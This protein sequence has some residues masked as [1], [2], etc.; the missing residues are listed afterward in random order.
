MNK[1]EAKERIGKLKEV[2]NHH[3]YL[4]HVLDK[5]EMSESALD[6][7][8]HELYTLEQQFP[9]LITSDSPTQRIGGQP[10]PAFKKVRHERP[11]LS[12]E[13]VFSEDEFQAWMDRIEKLIPGAAATVYCMPK[14]DGLAMSL[15]YENG[16]FTAA[17]T[18]GD[19]KFGEDVTQNIRTVESVPLR[20]RIPSK[21]E[22]E[23]FHEQF[24]DSSISTQLIENGRLE[25][26]GEIY[27]TK[28]DFEIM[29]ER[30]AKDG[31]ALFANPRNISAGSIRQLDPS[32][33][34]SRPLRFMA[35]NL[36]TDI[37][38]KTQAASMALL[39]LFGFTTP[40]GEETTNIDG[41]KRIFDQVHKKREKLPFWIDGLVVRV[42]R[43][44][45][46]ERLGVVGKTPR[47]LVA[48]KFSAEEVTTVVENIEWFVGRTG[49]ITPVA[50]V[51][52]VQ[53]GGTTVRHASLHNYDEIERL[54]VRV[55]DT[56]ILYKAGDII[57]KVKT[58]LV[59]LRP[60]GTKK[61]LPPTECPV[62]HSPVQ[63]DPEEVAIVCT[64]RRCFA[65]EKERVIHAVNAFNIYGL[66]PQLIARFLDEHLIQ[67]PADLFSLTVDDIRSLGEGFGDVLPPKL[68]SE[69]Q[70]K[71]QI[72]LDRF[73]VAL[74]IPN[75]GEE[76]ARDLARYFET[77]D[78]L[79]F[80]PL[81]EIESVYG[82][83]GV[84]A[85]SIVDFFTDKE[86]RQLIE[87]YLEKGIVIEVVEKP[88]SVSEAFLNKTFVLTGTLE[89][90][91]R[92]SA[93]EQI[94]VLGGNTSE[95]VSKKTD[96]VVVGAEAGS[97]EQKAKELGVKILSEKEF[98]DMISG[99]PM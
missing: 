50:V 36:E 98:V 37:G 19:G 28:K 44:D 72:P 34:A 93:K 73:I 20:L 77:L 1:S 78:R 27:V 71:K 33:A 97:K 56:I 48:W 95:S 69:I 5:Q 2:I 75:V 12:M 24:F 66:G 42:N 83:G 68:I 43:R 57:P 62:C 52:P 26:R 47:G 32:V 29:N 22:W 49:A 64:N 51:N 80:V 91:S 94:R 25:I 99:K 31:E 9:D 67:T 40:F 86:H 8:K 35:W 38:Q 4:Y 55:G 39:K 65:Q 3:R 59:D 53:V 16:L 18:R 41:V 13:D 45:V 81:E 54:D 87:T 7:L 89:S 88:L 76:T 92:E 17:A 30:R 14:V 60:K 96:Y 46:F 82:V 15:T 58:V 11:M 74:G 10:L 21:E 70:S 63:Q 6:S 85:K 84:V 61:T 90:M 79:M 23:T